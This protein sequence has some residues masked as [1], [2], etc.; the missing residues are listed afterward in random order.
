DNPY[1]EGG[2]IEVP[3]PQGQDERNFRV[4]LIRIHMEEDAGKNIH[5]LGED[6]SL[7]D[8]NRA[9]APLLEIISMPDLHSPEA[10]GAYLRE[11]RKIIRFLA[12]S[13]ANME[14]GTLR[15]D[16]NVSLR[17]V[18]SQTLGTRCEI[19]NL[20]S[21]KYLESAIRAEIRRQSDILTSGG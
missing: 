1:A 10:A 9:G 16:A 19:K 8:F 2:E 14:E 21:F 11:L 18:G 20:N 12:I 4:R 5:R 3:H 13:D 7:L 15:C 17:P 6:V